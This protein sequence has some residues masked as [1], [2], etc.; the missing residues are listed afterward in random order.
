MAS[1]G[2]EGGGGPVEPPSGAAES[3]KRQLNILNEKLW[4]YTHNTFQILETNNK[5]TT[6]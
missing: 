2:P 1:W 4:F 3:K 5:K 6:E